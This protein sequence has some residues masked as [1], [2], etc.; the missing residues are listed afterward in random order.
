MLNIT[1][2]KA[3]LSLSI[4]MSSITIPPPKKPQYIV[5]VLGLQN[6]NPLIGSTLIMPKFR[7]WVMTYGA[8]G[9]APVTFVKI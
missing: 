8:F 7:L 1:Q 5:Y 3:L 6:V 9:E 2:F 4:I